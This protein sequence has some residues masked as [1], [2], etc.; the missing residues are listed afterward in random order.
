MMLAVSHL[1]VTVLLESAIP[2]SPTW[3]PLQGS[4]LPTQPSAPQWAALQGTMGERR[5][6]REGQRMEGLA[7]EFVQKS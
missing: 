5:T 4:D 3:E 1:R 7:S 6:E 2:A